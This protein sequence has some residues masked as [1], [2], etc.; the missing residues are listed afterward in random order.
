MRRALGLLLLL[1]CDSPAPPIVTLTFPVDAPVGGETYTCYAFDAG[2]FQDRWVTSIT[3]EPPPPGDVIMHH[4]TL[5]AVSSWSQGD[6]STCFDMPSPATGLHVW[7]PGSDGLI[8]PSDM[9]LELPKDTSKLVVQVHAI[10]PTQGPAGEGQVTIST[11][12]VPPARVAAWLPMSAPIPA[13]RPHMVDSSTA[14]CTAGGDFHVI[15]DWPHMHLA[16]KEFH[17]AVVRQG[18]GALDPIVDVVPWDFYRQ[19]TY[20]VD[21]AVSAGDGVQTTCVWE[22]DT[23]SYIFG[24]PR[25][26]DEMCNQSLLV[27]PAA[28]ASWSGTCL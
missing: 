28:S 14:T 22:N 8:L 27:W 25:T 26:T 17:G 7:V 12:S 21:V 1:A 4:A 23:D 9:G 20:D 5:Y 13:L 15:R 11:T 24:G 19:E 16:G 10:R 3:W 6:V 2:S 18:T